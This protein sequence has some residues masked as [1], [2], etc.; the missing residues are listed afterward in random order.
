M[1]GCYDMTTIDIRRI[2][3]VT[4]LALVLLFAITTVVGAAE[5][6]LD[7]ATATA[8]GLV[9]FATMCC[10]PIILLIAGGIGLWLYLK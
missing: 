7:D 2:A 1:K 5:G 6:E 9:T 10:C 4:L 3:L 8:I